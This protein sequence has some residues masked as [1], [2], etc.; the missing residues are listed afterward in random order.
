M[1]M[2]KLKKFI[3]WLQKRKYQ[4][5]NFLKKFYKIHCSIIKHPLNMYGQENKKVNYCYQCGTTVKNQ[6][7]CHNCGRKLIWK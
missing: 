7:Y 1:K 2:Q 4:N 6:K 5:E 3:S